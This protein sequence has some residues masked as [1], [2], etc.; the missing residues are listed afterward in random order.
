M[1]PTVEWT[2]NII[3]N[4][5][6]RR[7]ICETQCGWYDICVPARGLQAALIARDARK[8]SVVKEKVDE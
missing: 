3:T 5:S 2:E 4:C 8:T 6:D 1:L 7:L